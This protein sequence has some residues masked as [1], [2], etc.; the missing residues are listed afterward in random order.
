[1][2]LNLEDVGH[3]FSE[4]A[5][6]FRDLTFRFCVGK[7]Y[8]LTGPSGSGKSTL[9]ALIAGWAAPTRG[10]VVSAGI[11]RTSWVFQNAH[12]M[13]RRTALDHVV[14]PLVAAGDTH[15]HA[16]ARALT[17]LG[18]FRLS[19]LAQR[20]FRSLSGGEAQRLMFARAV[21]AD[22]QLL[23]VDEPTAQLDSVTSRLVNDVIQELSAD[24]RIVIVASH[25]P[26]T[27]ASCDERLELAAFASEADK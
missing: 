11:D 15:A 16:E 17:M 1:M 18:R 13:A 22:P 24:G 20:P 12:G 7:S 3:R 23:L 21:A 26:D 4:G 27:V 19:D 25:D 14:F 2:Q 6:L 8:A 5:W 9:L 10:R